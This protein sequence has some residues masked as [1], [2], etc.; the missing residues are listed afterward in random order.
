MAET[1]FKAGAACFAD[2]FGK[3]TRKMKNKTVCSIYDETQGLKNS[4]EKTEY[5]GN[6]TEKF[7]ISEYLRLKHNNNKKILYIHTPFCRSK[8]TYCVCHSKVG[9]DSEINNYAES[10]LSDQLLCYQDLFRE[11]VFDEV[12]FGGG[13]PSLISAE[14]WENIY[15][16]IPNFSKIKVKSME[17]SPSTITVEHIKMLE[18]YGFS[19]VSLGIQSM[20]RSICQKYNRFY[21]SRE[22]IAFLSQLLHEHHLYFN[23][24]LICYMQYGDIRDLPG[25]ED[26]L[27]FLMRQCKPSSIVCHQL[28]QTHF[29]LEKTLYLMALLRKKIQEYPK[30][31]CIN[32]ELKDEDAYPDTIY[33]AEYRLVR[34]NRNFRHYMWNKYPA[35]PMIGYDVFAVGYVN[36]MS[37]KSNVGDLLYLPVKQELRRVVL[38]DIFDKDE[39]RIRDSKKLEG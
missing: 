1:A 3:F 26:D 18:H 13:T 39:R 21:V 7:F 5:E 23:Y 19:Y 16:L 27:D 11:I 17:C 20:N 37:I 12:Y 10:I 33:Q 34:E 29:T 14:Q 30:Y 9:T 2:S 25:F 15:S 36:N 8:C 32:A 6:N 4:P 31:E 22:Q 24:D 38:N 35:L 28:Y